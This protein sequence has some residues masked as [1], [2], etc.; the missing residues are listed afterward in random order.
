MIT[1]FR[2]VRVMA[3][4][5]SVIVTGS[6]GVGDG[7]GLAVGT[8]VGLAEG[9]GVGLT[10]GEAVGLDDGAG[11]GLPLDVAVSDGEGDAAD[12]SVAVGMSFSPAEPIST[13]S[14]DPRKARG[15]TAI[16]ITAAETL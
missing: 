7:V 3:S 12:V 13:S 1:P 9:V 10:V 11:V 14:H 8:G 6:R 5:S 2:I 15:A 16:R 4:S